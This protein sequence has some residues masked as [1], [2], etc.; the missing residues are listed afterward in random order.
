MCGLGVVAQGLS[1]FQAFG[2]QTRD[3]THVPSIGRQILKH[4]IA[5]EVPLVTF[6]EEK[7]D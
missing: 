3:S 7:G 5:R 2:V 1:C 4:W 6:L